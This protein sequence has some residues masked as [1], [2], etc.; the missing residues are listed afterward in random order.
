MSILNDF[1]S[2]SGGAIW[3]PKQV[4]KGDDAK[5]LTAGDDSCMIGWYLGTKED[6]GDNNS[7][8][9]NFK[10][11]QVGNEDHI[12]GELP[13]TRKISVWGTGVLDSKIVD[14]GIQVGQ[15][16]AIQWKGKQKP[17]NGGKPYHVWDLF[18][19]IDPEKYPPLS[20]AEIGSIPEPTTSASEDPVVPKEEKMV[21]A[22]NVLN[23]D[24]DDDDL[25]F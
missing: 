18:A 9:H 4:G 13:E 20:M 8:I 25:P 21:P 19:P 10:L 1:E 22:S 12:I 14:E 24:G 15:C 16:I 5:P 6:V 7:K 11:K 23:D 2:M 17:K 3:E